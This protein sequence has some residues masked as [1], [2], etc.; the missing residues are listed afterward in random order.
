MQ[1]YVVEKCKWSRIR[2]ATNVMKMIFDHVI[3]GIFTL[4]SQAK[5][6][7]SSCGGSLKESDYETYYR[8]SGHSLN[9]LDVFDVSDSLEKSIG[10]LNNVE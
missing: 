8:I 10:L 5:A 2:T 6:Y 9:G 7:V 3:V 4:R 1:V